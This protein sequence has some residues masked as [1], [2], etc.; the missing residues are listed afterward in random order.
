[1]RF[2]ADYGDAHLLSFGHHSEYNGGSRWPY[3]HTL[4]AIHPE[5]GEVGS[6]KYK[7]SGDRANSKVKVDKLEVDINHRRKGYGSALMDAMQARHPRSSIDHGDRTDL[8]KVWWSGYG[9]G[10]ADKRGR[11][12]AADSW[13]FSHHHIEGPHWRS[14]GGPVENPRQVMTQYKLRDG[15]VQFDS[16]SDHDY[17]VR[18]HGDEAVQR[19][20]QAAREHHGVEDAPPPAVERPAR[21]AP[22]VYYH[23][24]TAENVT[25][26]L[27]ANRHGHG[28]MFNSDTSPEHAYA[29]LDKGAAW[30]YAEMAHYVTGEKPRVYQVRPM[31]GDHSH[32]EDDPTWDDVR[33]QSRGNFDGDRRSKVGFEVVRELK[34][35]RHIHDNF[36]WLGKGDA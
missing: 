35:P 36:D 24:T 5:H 21:R 7:M 4:T 17:Q 9:E 23:G 1:M 11:T 8:G 18:K 10:K 22:R 32:V 31:H 19:V 14:F 13:Q 20:Q 3:D 28:V 33:N 2:E 30:H 12:A 29:S 15:G 25:H 27:P 34:T 26:V 6:L 16:G